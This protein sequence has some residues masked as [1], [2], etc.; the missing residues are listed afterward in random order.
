MNVHIFQPQAAL[1][2]HSHKSIYVNRR[3]FPYSIS[4]IALDCSVFCFKLCHQEGEV[5]PKL[6]VATIPQNT[7]YWV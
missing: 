6:S 5:A 3:I 4:I 7:F 1:F 2:S